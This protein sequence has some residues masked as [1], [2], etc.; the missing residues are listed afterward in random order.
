MCFVFRADGADDC[1]AKGFGP[2]TENQTDATG[3]RMKQHGFTGFNLVKGAHQIPD[4]E[5]PQHVTA[6][7]FVAHASGKFHHARG[8][9][10][11]FFGVA[12]DGTVA[13]THSVPNFKAGHASA[14]LVDNANAFHAGYHGLWAF[15]RAQSDDRYR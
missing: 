11:A 14:N 7:A 9:D 5:T 10:Q 6:D 2:L 4:S 15:C 12:A 3:R 1:S 13:I 8:W